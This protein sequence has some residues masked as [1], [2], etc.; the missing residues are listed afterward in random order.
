MA[1]MPKVE[2]P[3]GINTFMRDWMGQV[4]VPI[5]KVPLMFIF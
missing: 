3:P 2:S 5:W 4:G 1:K